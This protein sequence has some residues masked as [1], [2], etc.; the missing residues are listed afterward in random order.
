MLSTE[1]QVVADYAD[2]GR[3]R[4]VYYPVLDHGPTAKT[5]EASECAGEQG[6][7]YFWTI[8]DLFYE[9]QSR[10][11]SANTDLY[12]EFAQRAGVPN[13]EQFRQ[14]VDSGQYADKTIE[15]DRTRRAEGIRLRPSF[16]INGQL[17]PGAQSYQQLA[18]LIDAALAAA[19]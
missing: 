15:L 14:C 12:A 16:L 4:Y 7:E 19:E 2:A 5:Y 1:P 6:A 8:H 3:I 10:L 18:S 17:I 13:L 11:W 9:E